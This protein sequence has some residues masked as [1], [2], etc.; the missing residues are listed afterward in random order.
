MEI[1]PKIWVLDNNNDFRGYYESVLGNNFSLTFFDSFSAF[2]KEMLGSPE[3]P[4]L[5]I[6]ELILPDGNVVEFL[7]AHRSNT[8]KEI[9]LF[10]ISSIDNASLARQSFEAGASDFL[11]KPAAKAELFLKIERAINSN[12][13]SSNYSIKIDLVSLQI[14]N[15]SVK[16][17]PL[18][19]KELQIFSV[20]H[21]SA[22]RTSSKEDIISRIWGSLQTGSKTFDIHLLNL[23]RKLKPLKVDIIFIRPNQYLIKV[24]EDK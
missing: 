18:T 9:P 11:K 8:I 10:I 20:L 6:S 21:H 12:N 16:S 1:L 17:E 3:L 15:G 24:T 5:I 14:L 7:K 4:S 13:S 19:A 2:N 23:R 22:N